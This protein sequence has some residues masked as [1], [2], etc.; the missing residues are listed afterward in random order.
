MIGRGIVVYTGKAGEECAQFNAR[1]MSEIVAWPARG[2]TLWRR[3]DGR[4][5]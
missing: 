5:F 1:A 3:S 4:S 2:K